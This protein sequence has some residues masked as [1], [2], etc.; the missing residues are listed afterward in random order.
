[1][2]SKI[3][4]QTFDRKQAALQNAVKASDAEPAEVPSNLSVPIIKSKPKARADDIWTSLSYAQFIER[5]ERENPNAM[6]TKQIVDAA[7]RLAVSRSSAGPTHLPGREQ[8]V[9][10]VSC[11]VVVSVIL[12]RLTTPVPGQGVHQI[13]ERQMMAW[14]SVQAERFIHG[15]GIRESSSIQTV[16]LAQSLSM[17]QFTSAPV[18]M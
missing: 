6:L 2:A 3:S 10:R 15:M 16:R 12:S 18:S 14:P 4:K 1:M 13:L 7:F 5:V 8:A 17:R 11:N 9:I